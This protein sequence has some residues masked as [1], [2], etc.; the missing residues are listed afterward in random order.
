MLRRRLSYLA[1]LLLACT[2]AAGPPAAP[3]HGIG[4]VHMDISCGADA[5]ARFF[6]RSSLHVAHGHS[7]RKYAK[8]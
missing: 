3:E 6:S 5:N 1:S 7:S 2:L 4:N 8:S